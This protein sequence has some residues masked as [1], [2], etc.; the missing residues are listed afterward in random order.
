LRREVIR[1][2]REVI[3]RLENLKK[4]RDVLIEKLREFGNGVKKEF[5]LNE[6]WDKIL[7]T[8]MKVKRAKEEIELKIVQINEE[9]ETIENELRLLLIKAG[10]DKAVFETEEGRII[11]N[12]DLEGRNALRFETKEAVK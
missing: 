1:M 11:L 6:D 9:I 4:E 10:I 3:M 8:E 7:E 2:L 12:T 5:K